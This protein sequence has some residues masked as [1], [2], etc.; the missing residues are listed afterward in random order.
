MSF[1]ATNNADRVKAAIPAAL[2]HALIAY[3]LMAG[4]AVDLPEAIREQLKLIEILPEPP[5]P[6]VPLTVPP[7]AALPDNEQPRRAADPRP[8]G[9]ASPPN[10]R[11]TPTEV[12]APDPVIPLPVEPPVV[13]AR[14][15]GPGSD[16]SAG[17]ADVRGP[18]TGSG[19]FGDGFGSGRGGYGG[20]GGGGG[21]L[22][23][24]RWIRGRL[25]NSDYPPGLGE[26]GV[27]GT[28][29]VLYAVEVD[30]RVTDCRVTHSSGSRALDEM[31]CRLIEQRFRYEPAR[32]RSG[33]PIRSGIEE[34]HTW[35]VEDDPEP[36]PYERR[37]RRG[38]P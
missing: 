5:P 16:P 37:R 9:A 34:N 23:P 25:H 12:V 3:A 30:G 38:W 20:G 14:I 27:G 22:R 7:P 26:M 17:A 15:P 24:P 4:F 13:A 19:G 2:V 10:L 21:G 28:V 36:P 29:S 8:E 18:G 35:V 33:R 1:T 11:S 31:T 32:D 6:P